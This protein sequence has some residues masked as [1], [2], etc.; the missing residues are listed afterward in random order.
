MGEAEK[1][2]ADHSICLDDRFAAENDVL[3]PVDQ[4]ATGDFVARVLP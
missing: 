4:R 2:S 3:R 1:I